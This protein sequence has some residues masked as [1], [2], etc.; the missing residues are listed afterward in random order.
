MKYILLIT[1]F[2]LVAQSAYA[3]K[4]EYSAHLTSGGLAYRGVSAV[5]TTSID[6]SGVAAGY[7]PRTG[8]VYGKRLGLS[9]GA[10]AQ[11]QRITRKNS[12][13]GVQAGYEVLRS[14]VNITHVDLHKIDEYSAQGRANL[15]THFVNIHPYYGHRFRVKGVELDV[16]AGPEVGLMRKSREHSQ[17]I[18]DNGSRVTTDV[19]QGVRP[20]ADVRARV[21]VT[22]YYQR[23]GLSVGYAHGVTNYRKGYLGGTNDLFTQVFRAGLAYRFM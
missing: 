23:V 13:L 18:Y 14:R 22:A 17:A 5:A 7:G 6:L 8:N 2:I 9:Y 20:K 19:E 10:G 21:N 16:T 1:S 3:Q 11:V 15:A 4:T 12:L